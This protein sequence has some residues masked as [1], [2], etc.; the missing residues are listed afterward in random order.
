MELRLDRINHGDTATIGNLYVDGKFECFT[1]EDRVRPTGPKVPGQ[2]AIPPGTYPVMITFS[3]R[4]KRNLPLL[5]N[6]PNF[7]GI[8]IHPGNSADDTEGCILVGQEIA[9]GGVWLLRS[10]AAF[11]PLFAKLWDAE[12]GGEKITI[13]IADA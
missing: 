4:F 10:R 6:V 11:D 7:S 8:R 1:L 13:T 12:T 9:S 3:P 2:T 5:M